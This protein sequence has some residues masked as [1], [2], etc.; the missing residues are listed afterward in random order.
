MNHFFFLLNFQLHVIEDLSLLFSQ[1][2]KI[3]KTMLRRFYAFT[4]LNM[5]FHACSVYERASECN[6]RLAIPQPE[7]FGTPALY[8]SLF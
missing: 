5:Y 8:A 4:Y 7:D 3:G 6:V 1:L 2:C